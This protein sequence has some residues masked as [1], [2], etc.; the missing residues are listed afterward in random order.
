MD[1]K[2]SNNAWWR[3]GLIMF[4]KVS[5]SITV[6]ILASFFLGRY[7]DIKYHTTPWIFLSLTGV[8]FIISIFSIWK[9]LVVYLK[10]LEKEEKIKKEI[11]NL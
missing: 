6:P 8:A 9:N 1:N 5:I 7:L 4:A 11:N 10:D 2:P 3:P